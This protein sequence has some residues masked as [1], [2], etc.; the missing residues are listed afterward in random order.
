M[1]SHKLNQGKFI[2]NARYMM[3]KGPTFENEES[4]EQQLV[5]LLK[6][7][8]AED[9]ETREFL[10]IWTREQEK[11]VEQSTGEEY[12]IAQIQFNLKRA[13]LYFEGGYVQE[14]FENFEAARMQAWNEQ[15]NELC[16]KI[17]KEMDELMENIEKREQPR[18]PEIKIDELLSV[19]DS[20]Q[21]EPMYKFSYNGSN[22]LLLL[23]TE[24]EAKEMTE[25]GGDAWHH[26]STAIDGRDLY[27]LE[28]LS[29][30]E[31]RKKL[32]HEILECN[33]RDQGFSLEEAHHIA[34]EEEQKI[35]G[36]R[37]K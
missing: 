18:K 13:R 8:G 3:E 4:P 31:R 17:M 37:E 33:I 29:G 1:L 32:F 23:T 25:E 6:E 27:M 19:L 2:I 20:I 21:W 7:K 22:F 12:R 11:Q 30:E 28:S 15:R 34:L 16:Q 10:D 9:P 14:A 35:F 24:E 5:R 36:Q 26:T